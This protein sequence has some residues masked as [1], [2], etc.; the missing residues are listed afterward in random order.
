VQLG[1]VGQRFGLRQINQV[2][3]QGARQET[4]GLVDLCLK[5]TGAQSEL[6]VKSALIS[7]TCLCMSDA[8]NAA[9]NRSRGSLN[10]SG[11][12]R[13]GRLATDAC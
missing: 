11:Q 2:A 7:S 3:A 12:R 10:P 4:A 13:L 8:M 9:V 1:I 5:R 6:F